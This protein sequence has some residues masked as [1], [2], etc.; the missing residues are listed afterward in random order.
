MW[1]PNGRHWSP[2][3]PPHTF[4]RHCS[5]D[6][7]LLEITCQCSAGDFLN[8][9]NSYGLPLALINCM[10]LSRPW[11]CGDPNVPVIG[12]VRSPLTRLR[13]GHTHLTHGHLMTRD[14]PPRCSFCHRPENITVHHLLLDCPFFGLRNQCFPH[15]RSTLPDRQLPHVLSDSPDFNLK[16]LLDFLSRSR[17]LYRL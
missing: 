16:A 3:P 15:L 9:G 14:P 8:V 17:L 12:S 11:V 13:I 5:W 2:A 7:C 4:R 1:R 10:T 6:T